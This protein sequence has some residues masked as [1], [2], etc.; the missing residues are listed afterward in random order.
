MSTSL[1]PDYH[2]SPVCRNHILNPATPNLKIDSFE[3][4]LANAG[5]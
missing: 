1:L 3:R 5:Q 2:Q 4:S